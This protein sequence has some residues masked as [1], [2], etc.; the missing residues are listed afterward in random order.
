[1]NRFVIW[2]RVGLVGAFICWV[3]AGWI[4]RWLRLTIYRRF[5]AEKGALTV[6][7]AAMTAAA[8]GIK[9]WSEQ[10]A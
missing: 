7:S 2:I 1:M 5:E 4:L 6:F 3:L 8:A 9:W 10:L